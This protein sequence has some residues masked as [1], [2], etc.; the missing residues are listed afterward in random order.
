MFRKGKRPHINNVELG[1]NGR[2]RSN[3]WN[4]AGADSFS[5]E[6][7]QFNTHI[8]D[9]DTPEQLSGG[10]PTVTGN[11]LSP[12][13]DQHRIGEPKRADT[14]CNLAHLLAAMAT[15]VAERGAEIARLAHLRIGKPGW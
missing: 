2:H 4:Y 8:R 11:D 13:V 9:T 5:A 15:R 3:L 12:S 1:R 10:E 6:R 14:V 7:D